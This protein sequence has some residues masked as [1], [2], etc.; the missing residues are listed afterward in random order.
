MADEGH[1]AQHGCGGG[2]VTPLEEVVEVG[3]TAPTSPPEQGAHLLPKLTAYAG[4][5]G[6]VEGTHGCK[7]ICHLITSLRH[8]R[9]ENQDRHQALLRF[10]GHDL[11]VL[12]V[13]AVEVRPRQLPDP[14]ECQSCSWR[15]DVVQQG[16][17]EEEVYDRFIS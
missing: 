1:L 4:V 6:C 11:V 15:I 16:G 5:S 12:L 7:Y 9:V 10:V 8:P 13:A 14:R 3:L 2:P 17:S